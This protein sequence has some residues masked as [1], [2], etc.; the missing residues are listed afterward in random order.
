MNEPLGDREVLCVSQFTLYGDTRKGNRPAYVAAARPEH[1]EPLYE[2]FCDA[3]G[4]AARRVRR[5]HGRRARQRRPGDAAARSAVGC[6][7]HAARGPLRLP[8][9]RRAAAGPAALRPLGRHAAGRVPGRLPADRRPRASELGEAGRRSPGSPTARG[10]AARTC[11]ATT[12]TATGLELF[13]YVSFTPGDD[14]DEPGDFY[15]WAD[16]TDDTADDHPEWQMDICEE[17]IGGWRGEQRRGRG[18]DA[19][20]GR[21][22]RARRRG[23]DRRARPASPSTSA[24]SSRTASRCSRPTPT[25]TSTSTIVLWDGAGQRARARVALRGRRA[26]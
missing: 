1:A 22:A 8:L 26:T 25:A 4:R 23:R 20:L 14:D 19:R 7:A 5:A 21:P 13:G 3:P 6:G 15:A 10:R 24:R 12:R 2:R 11:P 18:D 16:Y 9:R 17:V